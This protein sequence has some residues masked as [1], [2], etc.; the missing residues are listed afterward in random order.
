[1]TREDQG[2]A[3]DFLW[4]AASDKHGAGKLLMTI[5][6]NN[7]PTPEFAINVTKPNGT[8]ANIAVQTTPYTVTD[9]PSVHNTRFD[10]RWVAS[11][12]QG[13]PGA[14][15]LT[16][17]N[18]GGVSA[19]LWY[20]NPKTG[21]AMD[22]LFWDGQRVFWASSI[23]TARVDGWI[24]FQGDATPTVV[25]DWAGEEERMAIDG[26][27]FPGHQGYEYLQSDNAD[28]SADNVFVFPLLDGR[29]TGILTHVEPNGTVTMCEPDDVQLSNWLPDP[30]P[31]SNFQ[32]P[33]TVRAA[34]GGPNPMDL[35]YNV[36]APHPFPLPPTGP[37]SFAFVDTVPLPQ[38]PLVTDSPGWTTMSD[39][40]SNSPAGCEVAT[41]QHLRNIG[42]FG[43]TP[44]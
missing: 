39:G 26:Y 12:P 8:Y 32:Y 33:G 2:F 20:S 1:M 5:T 23:A 28:G 7:L 11:P 19:D 30:T 14:Y 43:Q 42:Y 44:E 41:I 40:C 27:L 15:H 6:S 24:K 4:W 36:T 3:T 10:F 34:C 35:T 25:T 31:G 29:W 18:M 37:E 22:P 21:A 9:T 38:V 17:N 16:L 13:G